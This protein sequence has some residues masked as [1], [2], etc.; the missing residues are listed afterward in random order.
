MSI[1]PIPTTPSCA[2]TLVWTA[3]SQYVSIGMNGANAEITST[4]DLKLSAASGQDIQIFG[5]HVRP[6]NSNY[7]NAIDLGVSDK[8]FKDLYLAGNLK[9]GV[10]SIAI[11]DIASKSE[12]PDAVSGTN[13][14][15]NW[16]TITIG[17]A[18]YNIPDGTEIIDLTSYSNGDILS[19]ADYAKVVAHPYIINVPRGLFYVTQSNSER[20]MYDAQMDITLANSKVTEYRV[21]ILK[22]THAIYYT[23]EELT[24]PEAVSGTN[25]GTDWTSL[26]IGSTTKNIPSGIKIINLYSYNDGDALSTDDYNAVVADPTCIHTQ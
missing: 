25:D 24:V 16:T 8:R 11:A 6:V 13:N 9:D 20:Y 5:A 2:I 14:G 10:N 15:T 21:V 23:T 22:D 7:D 1:P 18:T 12:I 19:E 26:T 3:A 4:R 17:S